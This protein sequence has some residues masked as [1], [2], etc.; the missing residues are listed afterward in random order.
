MNREDS[1][2]L[3]FDG[4]CNLCT[5]SVQFVI[6]HDKR[7]RFLFASLQSDIGK[8]AV[9]DIR[10]EKGY[11]PDSLVLLYKGRYYI[12]SGAALHTARLLGGW[13]QL[14]AIFLVIPRFISNAVYD[15]VAKNRYRWF[16]RQDEC[17]VPAPALKSRFLH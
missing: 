13:L 17:M 8:K 12:K 15:L 3:F 10:A 1:P 11:T 6:K 4:V 16:G 9:E 14:A 2:V 5:R 7:Q